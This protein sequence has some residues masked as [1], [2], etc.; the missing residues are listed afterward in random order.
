MK[1]VFSVEMLFQK[2]EMGKNRF[3]EFSVT[4]SEIAKLFILLL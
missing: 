3:I 4:M 2:P 1:N